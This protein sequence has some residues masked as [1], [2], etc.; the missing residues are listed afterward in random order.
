MPVSQQLRDLG[1]PPILGNPL[2]FF[3]FRVRA[4]DLGNPRA[5]T[6]A[7]PPFPLFVAPASRRHLS[8]SSAAQ[9]PTHTEGGVLHPDGAFFT[10]WGGRS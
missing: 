9:L 4:N 2:G 5:P 10:R 3:I 6:P 1:H 7:D 8:R